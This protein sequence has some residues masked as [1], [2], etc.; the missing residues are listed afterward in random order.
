MSETEHSYPPFHKNTRHTRSMCGARAWRSR[1]RAASYSRRAATSGETGEASGRPSSSSSSPS[2]APSAAIAGGVSKRTRTAVGAARWPFVASAMA[3]ASA[4]SAA[5]VSS[6]P[7]LSH[8]WR[9][10]ANAPASVS[11]SAPPR[12][13]PPRS[14]RRRS[15]LASWRGY[16]LVVEGGDPY[17]TRHRSIPR[18]LA[19]SG[20]SW[21]STRSAVW[22]RSSAEIWSGS[23]ISC[24][25]V[26]V[27]L[28]AWLRRAVFD[29]RRSR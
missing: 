2:S 23:A 16:V 17:A 29:R 14:R 20:A 4:A 3:A 28:L 25:R 5:G 19:S 11:V 10:H 8:C 1:S 9:H 21:R 7:A 27:P 15:S 6:S 18:T 26:S 24:G 22:P 13:P 12:P